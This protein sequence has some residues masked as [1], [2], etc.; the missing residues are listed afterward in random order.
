MGIQR[1]H[2]FEEVLERSKKYIN[3]ENDLAMIKRAYDF[4]KVKHEGQFRKSG[5]PYV[6]HLIEVAYILTKLNAGPTT[7]AAGLLHDVVEDCD[8]SLDK[9]EEIFGKEVC[10]LVDSVTKIQRLKL[11]KKYRE[12][13]EAEDHKK[14]FI[15]MAKDIRVIIIKLADRLHNMRTLSS[16]SHDRQLALSRETLDVFAPIAHRLGMYTI[17]SELEDLAISYLEPKIV[18]E[19]KEQVNLRIRNRESSMLL[20]KKKLL[21]FYMKNKYHFRKLRVV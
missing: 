3:N 18:E 12:D 17:K 8:V 13:F 21:I 9:I 14:I 11:S 7:I 5:E 19:I 6:H 10:F 2:T 4:V 20:L 16:L 15:G 1:L